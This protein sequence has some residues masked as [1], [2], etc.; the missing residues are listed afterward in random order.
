M[1]T[2]S[3]P[4]AD[5]A[6]GRPPGV[7]AVRE[8]V[9]L[10]S[11]CGWW[12]ALGG[13]RRRSRRNLGFPRNDLLRSGKR[14]GIPA[15]ANRL[16][17]LHAGHDLQ[18]AQVHGGP[19]IAEERCLGGNDVEVGVDAEAVAVRRQGKAALR[20]PDGGVLLLNFLGENAQGRDCLLYTSPSPRD[21]S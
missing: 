15:P 18:D 12:L 2:K 5:P 14:R 8:R 16:D 19:L 7:V 21:C 1:K 9:R 20:G 4:F 10:G 11:R 6:K 13:L 3:P 17:Q